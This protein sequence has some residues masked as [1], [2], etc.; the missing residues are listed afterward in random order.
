M[1]CSK[2][3]KKHNLKKQKP[4]SSTQKRTQLKYPKNR[5]PAQVPKNK[6]PAQVPKIL[7]LYRLES[8]CID[9]N[10]HVLAQNL[11]ILSLNR[12]VSCLNRPILGLNLKYQSKSTSIGTKPI[13]IGL[14]RSVS[15]LTLVVPL[16]TYS[17]YDYV[18]L[19]LRLRYSLFQTVLILVRNKSLLL[20]GINSLE[21][22]ISLDLQ[23]NRPKLRRL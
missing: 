17:V 4:I 6:N 9:Q 15:S 19:K 20:V 16:L 11:P 5:N 18:I 23:P 12:S 10:R 1:K 22:M 8:A 3:I 7:A 21:N 2:K 14:N 13:S